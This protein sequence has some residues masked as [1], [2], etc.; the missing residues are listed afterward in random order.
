[1][2]GSHLGKEDQNSTVREEE[3]K[4]VGVFVDGSWG[5]NPRGRGRMVK[6]C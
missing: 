2:E 3:N 4:L 1:M 6:A 5:P